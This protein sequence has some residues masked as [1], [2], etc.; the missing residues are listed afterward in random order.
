[1]T[2]YH[3]GGQ[4]TEFG[5]VELRE[6]WESAPELV[7]FRTLSTGQNFTY[8]FQKSAIAGFVVEVNT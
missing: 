4:V 7:F 5:V 2:V 6:D 8:T 3:I 1:M